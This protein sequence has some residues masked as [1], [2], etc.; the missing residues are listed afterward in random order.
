MR[1]SAVRILRLDISQ[2]LLEPRHLGLSAPLTLYY[3][4]TGRLTNTPSRISGNSFASVSTRFFLHRYTISEPPQLFESP[5][6]VIEAT[7]FS[8]HLLAFSGET[9]FTYIS[10]LDASF[11]FS[12]RPVPWFTTSFSGASVNSYRSSQVSCSRS[13]VRS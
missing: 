7:Q 10:I 6:S 5:K 2:F 3:P 1:R 8:H 13:V 11:L 12:C 4:E 9:Y